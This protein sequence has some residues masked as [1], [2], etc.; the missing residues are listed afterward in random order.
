MHT[1]RKRLLAILLTLAMVVSLFPVSAFADAGE[2]E[3][4]IAPVEETS[5]AED[6]SPAEEAR[7]SISPAGEAPEALPEEPVADEI[8]ESGSCGENLTWSLSSGILR[9]TGSGAMEDYEDGASP[10][11]SMSYSSIQV[12]EGV[13][14]IGAYAFPCTNASSVSLPG[15][16][17]SIGEEAFSNATFLKSIILPDGLRSIGPCA[18]MNCSSLKQITLPGSISSIGSSAFSDCTGL[19]SLTLSEGLTQLGDFAFENCTALTTVTLP[20]TLTDPGNAPFCS[21]SSLTEIKITEG[22]TAL[23]FA[24]GVLYDRI[25]ENL[26][27]CLGSQ[28]GVTIPETVS[29]IRDYAFYCCFDLASVTI[30]ESVTSIGSYAFQSC[31]ALTEIRFEGN[32]P[33]FGSSP[34]SNITATVYYPANNDSWNALNKDL[35]GG[36]LTWEA[37]NTAPTIIASGSCGAAGS[38]LTWALDE[39]G[40]LTISGT[41]RMRDYYELD[42]DREREWAPAPWYSY[43]DQVTRIIVEEGVVDIG[44][45]AFKEMDKVTQVRLPSTLE[46]I[47]GYVFEG[48][49]ALSDLEIL[50]VDTISTSA[51]EGCSALSD[52]MLPEGIVTIYTRAFYNCSGLRS[53]SIPASLKTFGDESFGRCTAL[54]AV[55][56]SDLSAWCGITFSTYG[57][58]NPLNQREP[59]SEVQKDVGLYVNGEKLTDLVIPADVTSIAPRAFYGYTGLESVVIPDTVNTVGDSAFSTCTNLRSV[60]ADAATIGNSAFEYCGSLEAVSLGENVTAIGRYVFQNCGELSSVNIPAALKS[61]GHCAFHSCGKLQ[62]VDLTDLAAWCVISFST[63]AWGD[64]GYGTCYSNPLCNSS[65]SLYLNGALLEEAVIPDGV[66]YIDAYAFYRDS[67][68][69]LVRIPSTMKSIGQFAF[70]SCGNLTDVYYSGTQEQ[71]NA[72]SVSQ[73]N[74]SLTN[75][76][77]HYYPDIIASGTC[78]WGL[79]W[80]L[81]ENGLLTISGNGEMDSWNSSSGAPWNNYTQSITEAVLTDG[82]LSIGNYAFSG[83]SNLAH[84]TIPAS[85]AN[86]GAFAFSN[87]RSLT[88]VTIP[89]GVVTVRYGVF[90]GCSALVEA[91]IPTTVTSIEEEAFQNCGSLSSV[92]IPDGTTAIGKYAFEGCSGLKSVTL[93]ASVTEVGAYAFHTSSIE[94]VYI[95]DLDWWLNLSDSNGFTLPH[96]DLYVNGELLTDLVFPQSITSVPRYAFKN[97]RSLERVTMTSN[98]AEFGNEAFSGCDGIN[99]VYIDDLDWWLNLSDYKGVSLPHGDL[100]L[101]GEPVLEVTVPY[102]FNGIGECKFKNCRSLRQVNLPDGLQYIWGSAFQNCS[103]LTSVTV[104][105]SVKAIW[106]KAFDQCTAL[107]EVRFEGSAPEFHDNCFQGVEATVYYPAGDDTWTEDVRQSYGGDIIWQAVGDVPVPTIIASGNFGA[108]GNN[109]TWTLDEDGTL[110]ISGTGAMV[111][112]YNDWDFFN[113]YAPWYSDHAA[114]IRHIILEEGVTEIASNAFRGSVNLTGVEIPSTV[115]KIGSSSFAQCD[116]LRS[117]EI[118]AEVTDVQ[119]FAFLCCNSMTEIRVAEGNPVY[120]SW[121][122]LLCNKEQTRIIACPTGKSGHLD[123]PETVTEIERLAFYYSALTSVTIPESIS[124]IEESTFCGSALTSINIP[125]S[126]VSLGGNAFHSCETLKSV[127]IQEGLTTM[128]GHSFYNC[129]NLQWVALP[130]SL[131]R[132]DGYVFNQCPA[133]TDV[134]YA[135]DEEARFNIDGQGNDLSADKIVWHYGK[136]AEDV[137]PV[138]I[139]ACDHAQVSAR[140]AVRGEKLRL[141]VLPE[142]GYQIDCVT[143]NG[144][145]IDPLSYQVGEE[146]EIVLGVSVSLRYEDLGIT[147]SGLFGEGISWVLYE[148]NTLA[149]SGLGEIPY[150]Y[151]DNA[152]WNAYRSQISSLIL[153]PGITRI[154]AYAFEN[155]TALRSV[156]LPDGLTVID[157][158]SFGDCSSLLSAV[159]PEGVTRLPYYSFGGCT[160]MTHIVLPLSLDYVANVSLPSTLPDVVYAGTEEQRAAIEYEG[161]PGSTLLTDAVW[162]YGKTAADIVPVTLEACDHAQV[163][164]RLAVRGE[165]LRVGILPEAGYRIEQI[166]VNGQAEDMT[167]FVIGQEESITLSVTMAK[168]RP[169]TNILACGVC[170]EF[171]TWTL[172]NDGQLVINGTGGMSWDGSSPWYSYKD[173]ITEIVLEEGVTDI[174]YGAFAECRYVYSVLLPAGLTGIDSN[175]FFF[176]DSLESVVIP[177]S[178][179]EIG[180]HAFSDCSNLCSVKLPEGLTKLESSAF[181]LCPKLESISLPEG[182]TSIGDYAFGY[183]GLKRIVIPEHVTSIGSNAFYACYSLADLTIPSSVVTIGDN[184]FGS[185]SNLQRICIDDLSWWLNFSTMNVNTMPHGDLYVQGE[186]LEYAVIPDGITAIRAGAFYGNSSLR[187]LVLPLSVRRVNDSA[188]QGCENLRDVFYAGTEEDRA[189]ITVNDNNNAAFTDAS[190]HYG[191]TASDI[192]PVTVEPCEHGSV[193]AY[194]VRGEKLLVFIDPEA[195]YL[196]SAF[197]VNGVSADPENY[198]VGE[199]DSLTIAASFVP[200]RTDSTMLNSGSCGYGVKWAFY[201]DGELYF[202][203]YGKMTDYT[204]SI[205]APWSSL[206]GSIKTVVVEHGVKSIGAYAFQS[207]SSYSSISSITIPSSVTEMGPYASYYLSQYIN[208]YIDDLSWWLK[209]EYD[210]FNIPYGKLYVQGELLTEAVIPEDVTVIRQNAFYCNGALKSAVLHEGVTEICSSAFAC[211]GLETINLPSSLRSIG[212]SAFWRSCLRS[213]EIPAGVTTIP[214]QAFAE[215]GSLKRIA[216]PST[217]RTF[218][219]RAFYGCGTMDAICIDDLAW[220]LA[221]DGNLPEGQLYIDGE[222]LTS[223]V[224]PEGTTRIRPYAFSGC[225]LLTEIT[226]PESVTEIGDCA[227]SYTAITEIQLPERV[228][229][230]GRPFMYC[231]KL[232]RVELPEGAEMIYQWAFLGCSS[233]ESVV[234]PASVNSISTYAFQGCTSLKTVA[235]LGSA[236]SISQDQPTFYSSSVALYP[237]D[238]PSY[239]DEY[240]SGS[241]GG[242][243]TWIGYRDVPA[244]Y[245]IRYDLNG[246]EGSTPAEQLKGH[247]VD[248]LLS[249]AAFTRPGCSF[250]GWSTEAD[251]AQAQ[252]LPGALCNL[253]EDATLYAVWEPERYTISFDA[254]GGEGAPAAVTKI[255]GQSLTLPETQPTREK[256]RFLGWAESSSATSPDY[257]AGGSYDR[258]GDAVLYA[259]WERVPDGVLTLADAG[260]RQGTE[261]TIPVSLSAN[262]GI[263]YTR[264]RV[265][266]DH[267]L[268]ECLGV[269]DGSLTGWSLYSSSGILQWESGNLT[270][271]TASGT[272]LTLR[273]RIQETAEDGD[274]TVT[275]TVIEAFNIAEQEIL[276]EGGSA[277]VTVSSRLPGDSNGDDQVDI[278]DLVRLRKHLAEEHVDINLLNADVTGDGKVNGADLLRL[279]KYLAGDPAG[280]LK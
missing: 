274:T 42:E 9:I 39:T 171:L 10:W 182:L 139:E 155:C 29:G 60:S 59:G 122:G 219:D 233:L 2:N 49:A 108:Q 84:I 103:S 45:Y 75:A 94:K 81:D 123:I 192:V 251:A 124:R 271:N 223:V 106:D 132:I 64:P 130:L 136:T 38:S 67:D 218:E 227:F 187:S 201:E 111:N 237:I 176:C 179:T 102:D 46:T 100:Y 207:S 276:L 263:S 241:Y 118:P 87:C 8:Q 194:A 17:L 85:V 185:T 71:W 31:T 114:D 74:D 109:L 240:R 69:R 5:P 189:N 162:H 107:T 280:I 229:V 261:I 19:T 11:Y 156:Q 27:L 150:A 157:E 211:S 92:T 258:N 164:V 250:L 21:C 24:D 191:K 138:T 4:S 57:S 115:T 254:N 243:L 128:E 129:G 259:V 199:E 221:L 235:F 28:T 127:T 169:G 244:Y 99:I 54:E 41:G 270:D 154:G 168:R 200:H 188:F 104:P 246:G 121:N 152:P 266:Y 264:M 165:K 105:A 119:G 18:F 166:S 252:F 217:I 141:T 140:L 72:V 82:V 25:G 159:I 43:K 58:S 184:A 225:K 163:S 61:I 273:F 52:L 239:T 35:L 101:N 23:R 190:W 269:E 214:R 95:D 40:T 222:P 178:V 230:F 175:A 148:D 186:L 32:A 120:S 195:G 1:V 63:G 236:P 133:L 14:A 134:L 228:T 78:N 15:S 73:Y 62:R 7:G 146:A 55:R 268:L 116:A 257:L 256:H 220:W 48:C 212:S 267:S 153:D 238:D 196:L 20:S 34:F 260:G 79:T 93:P 215:C 213:V 234:L 131:T 68:L 206:A 173:S 30:P 88:S 224:L 51:F 36:K 83:C 70:A 210:H 44:M 172:Y 96:G 50:H 265:S 37:Y 275:L 198:I 147:D 144:T 161:N 180:S 253:N 56:I 137:V 12:G 76:T 149:I 279:R 112:N 47:W 22:N 142:A 160:A 16:L 97:C 80:T 183:S 245:S 126:V 255:Y 216:L 262:P 205:C 98:I 202:S 177:D 272:I 193:N 145:Q 167:S 208:N 86:I 13:T 26:L 117:I 6:L 203:G 247:N 91:S 53:V 3:G 242:T 197:T 232:K 125:S 89:E 158:H 249:G 66:T 113:R 181:Y 65:A 143:V 174:A 278:R 90:S 33:S 135:G 110:T 77:I 231:D 277:T 151:G 226:I 209:L 204:S 170:G 248:L